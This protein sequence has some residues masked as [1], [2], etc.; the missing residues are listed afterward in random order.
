PG[1]R[2]CRGQQAAERRAVRIEGHDH[3]PGRG[4]GLQVRAQEPVVCRAGDCESVSLTRDGRRETRDDRSDEHASLASLVSR[5]SSHISRISPMTAYKAPLADMRF[6][7]FDLLQVDKDYPR[8][9]GGENA[10]RDVVEAILDESAKF[11]EQ[12][13]APLN[14]SGDEEGC[15][16]DKATATVTTPTGFKN[17][18]AKY[19]EGGWGGR[20]APERYGGQNLPESIGA[21]IKEM[22]DSAN[23]SW[24][25][26]P[27]LS[28]GASDAL[29]QHGEEWQ[30]QV[31]LTPIIEGRWTGT[32]CLTE[33][34]CGSDLG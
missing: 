10:T 22:L 18:Y 33:P 7:M 27:L 17:A 11:C 29:R 21:P 2:V 25:N 1:P 8:L 9:A 15:H 12:V 3:D 23:L 16:F 19:V 28:H 31:F 14:A 26:F 24:G 20:T 34:H 4:Q 13:L 32:M 30:R 5:L 6:V